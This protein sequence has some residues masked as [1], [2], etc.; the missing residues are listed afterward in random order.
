V[1]FIGGLLSKTLSSSDCIVFSD[2]VI[3]K[4]ELNWKRQGRKQSWLKWSP[5]PLFILRT[6]NS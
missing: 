2:N 4:Y 6:W 3:S 1:I 5:V